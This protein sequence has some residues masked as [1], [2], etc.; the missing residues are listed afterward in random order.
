MVIMG[1][2]ANFGVKI[3]DGLLEIWFEAFSEDGY[4]FEQIKKAAGKIIRTKKDSYG[5]LPTYGEFIEA[6]EGDPAHSADIEVNNV[7]SQIR[8][9]GADGKPKLS[10]PMVNAINIRFGGWH[11]MCCGLE[12]SKLQ[13]FI[14]DLKE[15]YLIEIAKDE[16]LMLPD[17]EEAG[18]ILKLI[19][20]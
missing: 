16:K 14:R 13:W 6:I 3:P 19:K 1:L 4:T 15:A 20:S 7:V 8:D 10:I 18:R 17:K 12:E 9:L 2:A 11:N 5:R